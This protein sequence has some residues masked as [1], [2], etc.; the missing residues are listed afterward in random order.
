MTDHL[1]GDVEKSQAY[2]VLENPD[3]EDPEGNNLGKGASSPRLG[4][5]GPWRRYD[6]SPSPG[7]G[8]G[9]C[10]CASRK[11]HSSTQVSRKP[12]LRLPSRQRFPGCRWVDTG[13]QE[14]T[15]RTEKPK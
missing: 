8:L 15:A 5:R 13:R 7:P 12:R 4:F 11:H 14:T 1:E 3:R 2:R 10:H 9:H 6:Y